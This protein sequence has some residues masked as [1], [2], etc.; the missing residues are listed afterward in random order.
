MT[1]IQTNKEN[2][3]LI[4]Y[5]HDIDLYKFYINFVLKVN[6]F[7]YAMTTAVL[8]VVLSKSTEPYFLILLTFPI[9]LS[10]TLITTSLKGYPR[11]KDLQD[12]IY[13]R[14]NELGMHTFP[15]FTTLRIL[16]GGTVITHS[17]LLLSFCAVIFYILPMTCSFPHVV[18]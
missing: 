2:I 10:I 15:D 7:Q 16:I 1:D 17:I 9:I 6:A 18:P 8:S 4:D 13:K 12:G 11:V 14:A 5:Q 3:M